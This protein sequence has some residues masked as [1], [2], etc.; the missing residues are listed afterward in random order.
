MTLMVVTGLQAQV[1]EARSITQQQAIE[2]TALKYGCEAVLP[3]GEI[4]NTQVTITELKRLWAI[5][6]SLVADIVWTSN[7]NDFFRTIPD[8]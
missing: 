4:I 2:S 3:T 8:R 1:A 7:V 6:N 5:H